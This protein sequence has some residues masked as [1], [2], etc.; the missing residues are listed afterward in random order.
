M[1]KYY[2]SLL[3]KILYEAKP[4]K[5]DW[6]HPWY[7]NPENIDAHTHQTKRLVQQ[8]HRKAMLGHDIL[9]DLEKHNVSPGLFFQPKGT[10]YS[11]QE[12]N[13]ENIS[14]IFDTQ[15][16][17]TSTQ[18]PAKP[19]IKYFPI[20]KKGGHK[21]NKPPSG[22]YALD[23]LQN[24]DGQIHPDILDKF[25][26]FAQ[27]AY[28]NPILR[29]SYKLQPEN[30]TE[31]IDQFV[32]THIHDNPPT[33]DYDNYGYESGNTAKN[34]RRLLTLPLQEKDAAHIYYKYL[35][36]M[37]T[38]GFSAHDAFKNKRPNEKPD[39][40]FYEDYRLYSGSDLHNVNIPNHV[41][42][43]AINSVHHADTLSPF[44]LHK[45][46]T[47]EQVR[48]AMKRDDIEPEISPVGNLRINWTGIVTNNKKL[49]A[50]QLNYI[51]HNLKYL[52]HGEEGIKPNENLI[53][54]VLDHPNI[55]EKT[56]NDAYE[57]SPEMAVLHSKISPKNL[58]HFITNNVLNDENRKNYNFFTIDNVIKH[59]NIA[60]ET[61]D[62]IINYMDH[63]LD[64][65]LTLL[66]N[67]ENLH[68]TPEQQNKIYENLHKY[69]KNETVASQ[70][71][72]DPTK[73]MNRF[74]NGIKYLIQNVDNE[75]KSH[76]LVKKI[77][78]NDFT[79]LNLED[80]WRLSDYPKLDVS[81][82][83]DMYNKI[84]KDIL[85]F[86]KK[87]GERQSLHSIMNQLDEKRMK[88]G[89]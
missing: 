14:T 65:G 78:N 66:N 72:T 46:L 79:S 38:S 47:N 12:E 55:D 32:K 88:L 2:T 50:D 26:D 48:A 15:N 17:G 44:L 33:I 40:S 41:I 29:K 39:N 63:N 62:K 77:I 86:I 22:S 1:F 30:I 27:E 84:A 87:D 3:K 58:D 28:E 5:D 42:T 75:E 83:T 73:K 24:K 20:G 31:P 13:P 11:K 8:L 53:D 68:L 70:K 74:N 9:P 82:I 60:P 43:G 45:P 81:D 16:K 85:P 21:L 71:L 18:T 19:K 61:K 10:F 51:F 6:L 37:S 59:K 35:H 57:V 69:R 56:V 89:Y 36:Q 7:E 49:K 23:I 54:R 25:L 64:I 76:D 80:I 52:D 34:L 67:N 4:K